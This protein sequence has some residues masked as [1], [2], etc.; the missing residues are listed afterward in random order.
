LTREQA[1]DY[2]VRNRLVSPERATKLI[3]NVDVMRS[4]VI[5]YNLGRDMVAAFVE[6]RGGTD[7]APAK[8]WEIFRELLSSPRLP[9]DLQ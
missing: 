5:N 7:D 4:Y 6:R 1:R 9:S 2:L 8:R 3:T